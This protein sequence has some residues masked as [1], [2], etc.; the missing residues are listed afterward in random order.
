MH[1][2]YQLHCPVCQAQMRQAHPYKILALVASLTMLKVSASVKAICVGF[3]KDAHT[4]QMETAWLRKLTVTGHG[5]PL[6]N[7]YELIQ[8]DK[9]IW[10]KQCNEFSY[11]LNFY[12]TFWIQ[13]LI[14]LN[15]NSYLAEA[16]SNTKRSEPHFARVYIPIQAI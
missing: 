10:T 7:K 13:Q 11:R 14:N 3:I 16:C 2:T 1:R 4:S 8:W 6:I 12:F 15:N 5:R 9:N